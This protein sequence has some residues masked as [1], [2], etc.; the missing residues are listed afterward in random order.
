MQVDGVVAALDDLV[1]EPMRES[2]APGPVRLPGE[3]PVQVVVVLWIDVDAALVEARSVD[4]RNDEDGAPHAGR[5]ERPAEPDRRLDAG[6]LGGVDA[7]GDEHRGPSSGAADRDVRPPV[8]LQAGVVP[9]G[10]VA[11]GALSALGQGDGTDGHLTGHAATLTGRRVTR[12]LPARADG[13]SPPPRRPAAR[14]TR[15]QAR[16]RRSTR[17]PDQ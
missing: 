16:S 15:R 7:T 14:P 17:H 5:V 12:A 11:G 9:E 13:G 2:L 10:E 3:Q 6:V 8:L 1:E 4:E